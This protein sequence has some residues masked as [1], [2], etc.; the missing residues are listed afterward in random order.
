MLPIFSLE[1]CLSKSFAHL[2]IGLFVASVLGVLD[3]IP[4]LIHDLRIF[5]P[6]PEVAFPLFPLCSVVQ[7]GTF[8]LT[9]ERVVFTG[10][11]TEVVQ[12]I[13]GAIALWGW[14]DPS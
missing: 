6:T 1:K 14:G 7:L 9:F 4:P 3:I 13:G 8:D 10:F 5:S 2:I 12:G 11:F